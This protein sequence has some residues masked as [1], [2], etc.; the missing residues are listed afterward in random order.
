MHS[1]PVTV[2][3]P[4]YNNGKSLLN[5]VK[6]I[7]AQTFQ[8]WELILV[9]DGSTDGS[10]DVA[11]SIDD[12]RVRVLPRDGKNR[13]LAA[14]LNQIAQ[15]ARG[16]FI[17]R[18]DADDMSHPQRLAKQ[19]A[20]F[21]AHKD[22][23][24]LG[25]SMYVL[26]QQMQPTCKIIVPETHDLISKN[27]F[28]NVP[29]AHATVVA[30]AEWFRRWPYNEKC[31]I[32]QDQELWMRSLSR[33]NFANIAESLYLCNEFA[34]SSLSKYIKGVRVLAK[35][36]MKYGPAEIGYPKAM[37]YAGIRYAKTGTYIALTPLGLRKLLVRNRYQ[38]LTKEEYA[39]ASN[40]IDTIVK[41]KPAVKTI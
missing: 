20:F 11:L 27:R 4:F 1:P 10:L 33:S 30:K 21:E 29:M 5:A 7:F 12:P 25:T 34:A 39:D 6:S 32:T 15:A 40:A 22:I 13:R 3:I 2:G 18:M 26:N 37:Y 19:L 24:V 8:D 23:D 9:D 17:A 28:K 38:R 14:R 16:E 36:I 41:T 35:N 31:P